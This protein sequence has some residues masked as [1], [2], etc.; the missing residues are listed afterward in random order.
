MAG[1]EDFKMDEWKLLLTAPDAAGIAVLAASSDGAVK[2]VK[3]YLQA[4]E[5]AQA[6]PFADS[7]VVLSLIR[8]R[9]PLGEETRFQAADWESFSA[10]SGDQAAARATELCQQAV[11]LLTKKAT[12][13]EVAD[14]KQFVLYL[15]QHVASAASSGGIMGIGGKQVTDQEQTA[16]NK[17]AGALNHTP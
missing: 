1:L 8:N 16:I 6:Q 14:Y 13:K 9:D 15:C 11:A 2:E 17:I 7:Q 3:A 5:A 10:T 12:P 4:W